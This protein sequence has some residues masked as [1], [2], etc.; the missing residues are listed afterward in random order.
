[1]LDDDGMGTVD[2]R[3]AVTVTV[4]GDTI[5][6]DFTGSSP[7]VTGNINSPLLSTEAVVCYVLVVLLDRDIPK[8][9]GIMNAVRVTAPAGT[10]VNPVFPAPVAA[11]THTCQRVADVVMG[12]L[13]EALPE[14]VIAASN[15]AN[16]TA[17]LSGVDPRTGRPYLL[18]ETYGGGCG[19]RPFRD[20]KD[21]VQIHVPN[22]ANT[23]IEV[24]ENEY[25][26]LVEEYGWAE[27]TGGAGKF[28]GGLGLRRVL[29][30]LDHTC[31][32]TGAGERFRHAPWGVFGGQS[33]GLGRYRLLGDDGSELPLV[34]KPP[35]QPCRADQRIVIESPGA[36]GYGDPHKRSRVALAVD[37]RSGKF[38]PDFI[39]EHYGVEADELEQL[40]LEPMALDYEEG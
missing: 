36:G 40:A 29:R 18:F 38:S 25:P 28:R 15:G 19:G 17:I 22:A 21:G 8:N 12:A 33:G 11:R 4:A 7:Q 3:L 31:S 9:Q 20:G 35:P 16:T 10:I 13:V 32:F 37:L 30:P 27:D 39:R 6:V 26:I 1:M 14:V 23:P 2:I 34:S 5:E 24:L